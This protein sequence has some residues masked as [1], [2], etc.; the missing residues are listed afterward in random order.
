MKSMIIALL[1]VSNI[2][3]T[4]GIVTEID[5]VNDV[6][7]VTNFEGEKFQFE[8]VEDWLIGDIAQMVMYDNGTEEAE[9]D[10]IIDVRYIGYDVELWELDNMWNIEN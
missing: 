8:E 7:T 1:M 3:Q 10:E 2:Y 9:D 4:T 6:V 5:E